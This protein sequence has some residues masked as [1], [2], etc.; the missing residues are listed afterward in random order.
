ML[1]TLQK[2]N[3]DRPPV[4]FMRQAGR[5]LREYREL[6]AKAGHF[7]TMCYT[8]EYATEVTMQPIRRFGF[9][10]AILFSDILVIPDALGQKVDFITGKGPVLEPLDFNNLTLEN[11]HTHLDPVYKAVAMIRAQLD[12]E[13]YQDTTLIGFA[14]SPFTVATY[15]IEGSGTKDFM[16]FKKMLY[17]QPDQFKNLMDLL[18]E[19]TAQYLIRQIEAGAEVI[20]LFESWAGAVG[21]EAVQD[22]I[23]DT[24]KKIIKRVKEKY[25]DIPVIGFPKAAA[26]YLKTYMHETGIDA[27]GCDFT[28]PL[29]F[30]RDELQ[31]IMPVQG[32]LD[33][34]VLFAGG[35][36]LENHV[37]KIL[38][39]LSGKPYIFNLGHGIHKD[40]PIAHVEKT[41]SL[42]HS[43]SG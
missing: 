29:E 33:P 30:I 19:A 4:W 5:Y 24:N 38:E 10:A 23:I 39:T 25:P 12:K 7:L 2:V 41:L 14:G 27:L 28:L 43:Y 6:R 20:Q 3:T 36:Q 9:D 37:M 22:Y 32:N 18:C 8:P 15:M 21:G 31:P 26:L 34:G 11:L 42:I 17:G 35:D 16:Q 40:T 1:K 13:G